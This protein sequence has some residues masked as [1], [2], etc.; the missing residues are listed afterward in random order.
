MARSNT[1]GATRL[2]GGIRPGAL[3]Y[4]LVGPGA[5]FVGAFTLLALAYTV[6]ASFTD[7]DIGKPKW[8]FIGFGNFVRAALDPLML[9]SLAASLV[10]VGS[11]VFLSVVVGFAIAVALNRK[12][13][14]RSTMRALVV[15]PWVISEL[16]TG[17]FWSLLLRT[18]GIL[19]Q[20]LGGPLNSANGAMIS[21]ILVETW[22][23]VGFVTVMVLAS[24][25]S[26]DQSLYEAAKVDGASRF[27]ITWSITVPLV[28]PSLV[29]AAILLMVGNFNLVTIIIALTGGGPISAT[30]T[31][32]LY[33][34]QQ[35]FVYF[36]IGYGATIAI[37]MSV[38]NVLA[39]MVFMAIQ[40]N[41][42]VRH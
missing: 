3:P 15:V 31:T 2:G 20:A 37:V 26:I 9:S 24:L 41:V 30:T 33:M 38:V 16:A 19:G 22:R 17:V 21:L 40:K 28:T 6:F 25:Q 34:Y 36:H 12:F 23:S 35:S 32:A 39:M 27:R 13:R 4:L 10:F 1:M 14:G 11:V 42:G 29:T 18:D 8:N 7:W 5:V